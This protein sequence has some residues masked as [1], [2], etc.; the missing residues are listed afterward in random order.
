MAGLDEALAIAAIY[1]VMVF[2]GTV[3]SEMHAGEEQRTPL[4]RRFD[5]Q[6]TNAT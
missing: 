1:L 4:D 6:L 5:Y 2:A 3:C